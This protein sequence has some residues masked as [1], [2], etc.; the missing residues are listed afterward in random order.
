[1]ASVPSTLRE[2]HRLRAHLRD[3]QAEIDRGPRVL[4]TWQDDL[5]AA[6]VERQAHF[7]AITKLKLKQREDEGSL[8]QTDA[9]LTKL[10]EQLAGISVPKEYAAKE[11]EI[12]HTKAKKGELEDAILATITELEER[13]AAIPAV[14]K[15]WADAQAEFAQFQVEAA[16]RLERLHADT[17]TSRADLA[18]AEAT[19]PPDVKPTYDTIVRA[20]GPEGFAAAKLR[21][22]QGC[23]TSMTETQFS[24]LKRG[25]F[26]TC[27]TCGRMQYPVE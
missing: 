5:E 6:R 20:K 12:A 19:L 17:E 7:D 26:R 8:K 14:E 16:E 1:M 24:E 25:T 9:R 3:L 4:K 2:C 11:V 15:K 13:T 18:R 23:R 10:E 21:T 22:C 27:T